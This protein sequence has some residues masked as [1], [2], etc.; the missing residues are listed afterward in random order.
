MSLIRDYFYVLGIDPNIAPGEEGQLS[1]MREQI[2]DEILE[3]AYEKRDPQFI[4]LVESYSPG[5][6][7]KEL[8]QYILNLYEKARSHVQPEAWLQDARENLQV[9]TLEDL[10]NSP[11]VKMIWKDASGIFENAPC[12]SEGS[13]GNS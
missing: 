7:D 5:R 13:P 3:E 2:L 4:E 1:L 9:E 6:N 12:H 8:G 10:E 11:M